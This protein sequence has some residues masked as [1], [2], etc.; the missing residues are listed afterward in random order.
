[1]MDYCEDS[2]PDMC[3]IVIGTHPTKI[4]I[5]PQFG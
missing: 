3:T 5:T 4:I 1:M 2:F